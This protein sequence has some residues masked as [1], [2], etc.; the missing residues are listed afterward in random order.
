MPISKAIFRLDLFLLFN[1]SNYFTFIMSICNA[2]IVSL[3]F[4][5]K[6]VLTEIEK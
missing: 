4:L 6:E 3:V 1:S 2:A 5:T